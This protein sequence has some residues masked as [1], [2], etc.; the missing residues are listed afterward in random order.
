M[1]FSHD[2]VHHIGGEDDTNQNLTRRVLLL[3]ES[4]ALGR[5]EAHRRVVRHLLNRY[6]LEDRGFWRGS[7]AWI[8]RFLQ[9]DSARYWRTMA[10][11]FAYKVRRETEGAGPSET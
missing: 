7:G 8:P 2:I 10:V 6:L 4:H 9:N 1:V 11:D 5:D 3:L